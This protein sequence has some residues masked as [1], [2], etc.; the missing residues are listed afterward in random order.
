MPADASG[1]ASFILPRLSGTASFLTAASAI[2]PLDDRLC[3]YPGQA[4][5]DARGEVLVGRLA[6]KP[7]RSG[8]YP[9]AV[10]RF[11]PARHSF[12]GPLGFRVPPNNLLPLENR[13]KS[14]R[15]DSRQCGALVEKITRKSATLLGLKRFFTGEP[16]INGH[17]SERYTKRG[18]ECVE[19]NRLSK[20]RHRARDPERVRQ[21]WRDWS[22]R[23]KCRS[24]PSC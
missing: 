1:G 8:S 18:G 20:Q 13:R 15:R 7:T 3:R 9:A 5:A 4:R 2:S 23:R 19:C 10:A 14:G 22:A 16:C 24:A 6:S 12:C 11:P 21:Q 17:I